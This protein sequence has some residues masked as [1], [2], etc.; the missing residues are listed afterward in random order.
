[1]NVL[2]SGKFW[3]GLVLA[4][5]IAATI[6]RRK[7]YPTFGKWWDAEGIVIWIVAATL[8]TGLLAGT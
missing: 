4:S 6:V 2:V 7:D 8:I 1:V 3:I 5:A